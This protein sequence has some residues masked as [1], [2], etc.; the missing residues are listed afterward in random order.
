MRELQKLKLEVWHKY[1][2][3]PNRDTNS[4]EKKEVIPVVTHYD[5]FHARI[6]KTW[7]RIIRNNPVFEQA[8]VI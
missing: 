6:N 4:Q 5:N 7:C 1:A 2:D 3:R 8:R